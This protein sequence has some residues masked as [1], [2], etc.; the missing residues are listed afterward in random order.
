MLE[1]PRNG[2]PRDRGAADSYS[3]RER[4]PHMYA[5]PTGCGRRIEA[6]EMS[7]TEICEYH[8][9]FDANERDGNHKDWE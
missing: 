7:L 2:S 6:N 4:Q 1:L 5:G 3:R 9:G 8:D